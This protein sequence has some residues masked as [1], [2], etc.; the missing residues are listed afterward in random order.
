MYLCTSAVPHNKRWILLITNLLAV[1][2]ILLTIS[3]A[4]PNEIEAY[5]LLKLLQTEAKYT[6][7]T[8]IVVCIILGFQLILSDPDVIRGT[9]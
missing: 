6:Q 1:Q 7:A 2:N 3:S 5:W 9:T 4:I 8:V